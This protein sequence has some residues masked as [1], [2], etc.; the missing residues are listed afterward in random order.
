[1]QE[2]EE[3]FREVA[4]ERV[5]KRLPSALM[6][7]TK[8]VGKEHEAGIQVALSREELAQMTGTTLFTVSRIVSRWGEQGFILPEREAVVVRVPL[9]LG[10]FGNEEEEIRTGSA[11]GAAPIHRVN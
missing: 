10:Q 8:Q 4:T 9:P 7:L 6:R 5:A 1:L 2:L 11:R 3:R